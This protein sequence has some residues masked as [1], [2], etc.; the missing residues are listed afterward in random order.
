M[1]RRPFHTLMFAAQLAAAALLVG[2][3]VGPDFQR[4]APPAADRYTAT[5]PPAVLGHAADAQQ[6]AIGTDLPAQWWQL[7]HSPQL[8]ALVRRAL[9]ANPS[10][11]AAQASLRQAQESLAAGNSARFPTV[12]ADVNVTRGRTSPPLA[13][14][15]ASNADEYQ[16]HTAQLETSWAPDLFGGTRR[17]LEALRAQVDVQRY[18]LEAA[19]LSLTAN[20]IVAAINQASLRAQIEATQAIIVDQQHTLNSVRRQLALGQLAQSDLAA[21]QV[22]LAQ[23]NAAL[24]PL[25]KQLDQENDALAALLGVP[26]AQARLPNFEL[27]DLHLPTTLP[28]SLPAELVAHRPDVRAAEAQWHAANAQIGVAE[29]NR[30]P[31]LTITA[32]LGGS[33][34]TLGELLRGG[35]FWSLA[36]DVAHPV[37]DAGNLR[38]QQGAAVAVRDAAAAQYRAAVIGAL[39]GVAD[40]LYALQGDAATLDATRAAEQAAAHGL[41]IS[42]R[43][44]ALGATD[45]LA[46]LQARQAWQQTRIGSVQAAAARYS[47]T[48]ALFQS[49][50][51]GWWHTPVAAADETTTIP[52]ATRRGTPHD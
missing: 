16:L 43:E 44:L 23:S 17:T 20:V 13:S 29:A 6:L 34:T 14:P 4:P 7:F 51:G 48:V 22:A 24:P 15:V 39:Q 42:Q 30:L 36:G 35:G 33:A 25:Q 28:L 11:A 18:Q 45:R 10:L 12:S 27:A 46:L 40:A 50:G 5:E 37:F 47:D 3:T 49:L 21:Q 8:D 31:K 38:H 9:A 19:R 52:P 2:C 26:P 41:A 32:S 1:N